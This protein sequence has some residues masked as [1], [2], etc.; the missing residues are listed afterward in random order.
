MADSTFLLYQ[1]QKID[2]S[3]HAAELTVKKTQDEI[4]DETL[5]KRAEQNLQAAATALDT[6]KIRI[7]ELERKITENKNKITQF[8][9][10]LYSGKISNPKELQD[11]QLEIASLEKNVSTLESALIERMEVFEELQA[12]LDFNEKEV[13]T[14]KNQKIEQKN[15]LL[16]KLENGNKEVERF[17]KEK[18]G[19]RVQISSDLLEVYDRLSITKK[20]VAVSLVEEGCCQACGTTLT[21]SQCQQAKNHSTLTYCPNCGRILY[22]G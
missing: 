2:T 13:A 5:I 3:Q 4:A 20:G 22:A 14:L 6:E 18:Q 21:P 1:L 12:T 15:I 10:S 9:S 19:I 16:E 8:S 11:L 7:A 17:A